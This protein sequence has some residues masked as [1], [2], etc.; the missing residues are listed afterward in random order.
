[1]QRRAPAA[2]ARARANTWWRC[3]RRCARQRGAQLLPASKTPSFLFRLVVARRRCRRSHLRAARNNARR[4]A[5]H[6]TAPMLF[7][8]LFLSR[9]R[10]S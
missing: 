4:A 8:L 2:V 10:S 9:P 1:M 3:H 5:P 7:V 6:R